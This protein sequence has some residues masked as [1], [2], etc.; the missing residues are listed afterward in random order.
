VGLILDSSVLIAA[1]RGEFDL[2]ALLRDFDPFGPPA[3][4]STIAAGELLEGVERADSPERKEKRRI[5]VER[6]LAR[7]QIHPFALEDA[8]IHAALKAQLFAIG[9]IIGA[10]DLLIAATC[11]R[12]DC[13]LATLN[14]EE[15]ARVPGLVLTETARYSS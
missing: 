10:H 2:E 8:R 14:R 3:G 12:L 6:V 7:F 9:R 13:P 4:I 11:L 15:F 5:F 1:E